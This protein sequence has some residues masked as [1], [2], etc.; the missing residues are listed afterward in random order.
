MNR[1]NSIK[2]VLETPEADA[3]LVSGLFQAGDSMSFA[4]ALA[5]TY[6]LTVAT[7][8]DEIIISGL[9]TQ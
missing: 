7:R 9:P 1:Y 4:N 5:Q 8:Q 3:L 2:L 6:G